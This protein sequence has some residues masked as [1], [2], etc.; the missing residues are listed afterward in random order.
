MTKTDYLAIAKQVFATEAKAVFDL[1]EQLDEHFAGAVQAILDGQ[2]K[3]TGKVV[4]CG[5]GKSGIIGKKI[6]ATFASTGTPSFF[7]HPGEAYH[8]DLGMVTSDDVFLAISNSGETEE[9]VKLVPFLR[10]NQNTLIA[11][12]G[13]PNSSLAKASH[14]HLNIAVHQEACPLQLAPTSSTTATVAMGDALAITMMEARGFV[15]EQFAR[16]HPGGSLGR[17]LLRRVADEMQTDDL[18]LLNSDDDVLTVISTMSQGGLGLAIVNAT[19][20]VGVI[21]DGDIRR[22]MEQYGKQVFVHTAQDLMSLNPAMVPPQTRVEDA[23]ALMEE[24]QVTRLLVVS[25]SVLIGVFKK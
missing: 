1:S 5:M 8:G 16:F 7:M 18:P 2:A 6:A 9:V 20:S 12:T 19:N 3:G 24:K 17:R 13:N 10:D 22:A 4:V 11:M 21:T 14:F 15:P 23:L 25:E